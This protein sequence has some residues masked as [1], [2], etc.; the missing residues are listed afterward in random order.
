M[1]ENAA[2]KQW[3][4]IVSLFAKPENL[5]KEILPG[6]QHKCCG[7]QSFQF[8]S[9]RKGALMT[10]RFVSSLMFSSITLSETKCLVF[11]ET[12]IL[13]LLAGTLIGEAGMV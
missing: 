1:S 7:H 13:V 8:Y 10:L 2:I 5:I 12:C 3:A 11:L 6:Y 9:S 4:E